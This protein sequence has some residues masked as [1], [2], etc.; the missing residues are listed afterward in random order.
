MALESLST[1]P[2]Y[3]RPHT[4]S[5]ARTSKRLETSARDDPDLS[6]R[7][8]IQRH[9]FLLFMLFL[10]TLLCAVYL[11]FAVTLGTADLCPGLEGAQMA[12]CRFSKS[13]HSKILHRR[14]GI[15]L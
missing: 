13:K 6:W 4:P 12:L 11:Y 7:S 1:S 15:L 10:L 5:S 9:Q 8:L 2:A 3:R 14:I